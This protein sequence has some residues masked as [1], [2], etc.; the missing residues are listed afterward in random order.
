MTPEPLAKCP[1]CGAPMD[2][3]NGERYACSKCPGPTAEAYMTLK[4]EER[5]LRELLWLNHGHVSLYGDD[6]EMQC[7]ECGID[8][9]RLPA[10]EIQ[11]AFRCRALTRLAAVC[12]CMS[13]GRYP[14]EFTGHTPECPWRR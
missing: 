1:V 12:P 5:L 4:A 8:F 11:A 13:Q 7:G 2:W 3:Y 14:D 10:T 6:G 9:K